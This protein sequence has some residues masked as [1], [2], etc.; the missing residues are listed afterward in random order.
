MAQPSEPLADDPAVLKELLA[1]KDAL[2][3]RL[4]EEITRLRRWRFGRS[5]ERIDESINPQLP[6]EDIS[7]GPESTPDASGPTQATK[8]SAP[9]RARPDELAPL[10]TARA[11]PAELPRQTVVHRPVNCQCP[12]CG[13]RMRRLGEDISEMLDYVPGHFQVIRHVRP[14]L[15]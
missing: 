11:L 14:K 3:C 12:E 4:I 9:V 10:R 2:I 8:L 5:A 6:L 1:G 7:R 15:S 13:A